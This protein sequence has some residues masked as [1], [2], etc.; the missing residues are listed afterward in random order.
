[1]LGAPASL[2]LEQSFVE[3]ILNFTSGAGDDFFRR[4]ECK[5]VKI[6]V[7][8]IFTRSLYKFNKIAEKV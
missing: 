6:V 5:Q 2:M 1:M 8:N 7:V 3:T 4:T